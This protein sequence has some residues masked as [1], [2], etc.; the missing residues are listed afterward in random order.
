M[1][2]WA[3]GANSYGQLAVG[4]EDDQLLPQKVTDHPDKIKD[5]YGGGGHTLV[6][7]E[8]GQLYSCGNNDKGQLG[9]N[10]TQNESRLKHITALS[11]KTVTMAT[12]GWDFTLAVTDNNELFSWG[13]NS[14][15]Q[16][17]DPNLPNKCL[18]PTRIMSDVKVIMAAAGLRH[19]MAL[20]DDGNVFC[21]GN[22]K[23]GQCGVTSDSK[24]PV[25]VTSPYKVTIPE[26]IGKVIYIA[27][28]S[29][30][31]LALSDKGILIVWGCNKYGQSTQDPGIISQVNSPYII[32]KELFNNEIIVSVKSGWT[33]ILAQTE[34]GKLYS[35]GRCDYGQLGR[36]RSPGDTYLHIPKVIDTSIQVNQFVCGSEHNVIASENQELYTFG[37]NE[38]GLCAT[39]DEINQDTVYKVQTFD[40]QSATGD[41]TNQ[42]TVYEVQTLDNQ[43]VIYISCGSGHCFTLTQDKTDFG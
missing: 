37:W 18:S 20:T 2:L 32:N 4:N 36:S 5:I 3:W 7:S 6:I 24:L 43:S 26:D 21:W 23:R 28:G 35:W 8:S 38:H 17:G 33:H 10:S 42:D 30:H 27:A 40:N 12:G 22:G 41:E 15:G 25:K 11:T 29:Y 14:F 34:T 13:S 9:L 39:G 31:S 19:S 1:T 16:L